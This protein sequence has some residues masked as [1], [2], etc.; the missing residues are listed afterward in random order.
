MQVNGTARMPSAAGGGGGIR[1]EE[2]IK[3]QIARL[4]EK[5]QQLVDQA[6][7]A[8]QGGATGQ[9]GSAGAAA[10]QF[11][12]E[13]SGLIGPQGAA[14]P[15]GDGGQ[16]NKE[17]RKSAQ[18]APNQSQEAGGAAPGGGGG[19][20]VQKQL[21]LIDMQIRSLEAQLKTAG[22]GGTPAAEAKSA[23]DGS[24][25]SLRLDGTAGME[26]GVAARPRHPLSRYVDLVA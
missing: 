6:S 9:S 15:E 10:Q 17:A 16:G 5:R 18:G 12:S 14:R 25:E 4:K 2:A 23:E 7:G 3:K 24:A 20:D 1:N 26:K 13:M 22:G 8:A 21:Q 19:G 11:I